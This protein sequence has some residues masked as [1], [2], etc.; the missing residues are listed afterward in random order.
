MFSNYSPFFLKNNRC[1]RFR[2]NSHLRQN[3]FSRKIL[4]Y[5]ANVFG[6]TQLPSRYWAFLWD[7]I[8]TPTGLFLRDNNQELL[9]QFIFSFFSPSKLSS[10]QA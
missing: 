1:F 3:S 7:T 4:Y 5:C 6:A 8:P 9:N 2:A 10:L